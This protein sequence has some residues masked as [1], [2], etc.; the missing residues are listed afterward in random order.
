MNPSEGPAWRKDLAD[1]AGFSERVRHDGHV[2]PD[3]IGR[4][5]G[6]WLESRGFEIDAITSA[7]TCIV[8]AHAP[9]GWKNEEVAS[10]LAA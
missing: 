1:R 9:E 7:R 2:D 4:R 3:L 10:A 6:T 8:K 5:I